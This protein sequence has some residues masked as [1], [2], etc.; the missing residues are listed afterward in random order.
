MNRKY[1]VFV[2]LQVGFVYLRRCN[3]TDMGAVKSDE[4]SCS[5]ACFF[6]FYHFVGIKSFEGCDDPD[7]API[8]YCFYYLIN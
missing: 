6:P 5:C 2:I 8:C 3:F 4:S 1:A 7:L